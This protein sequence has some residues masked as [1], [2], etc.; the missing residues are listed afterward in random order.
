MI[1]VVDRKL[2]LKRSGGNSIWLEFMKNAAHFDLKTFYRRKFKAVLASLLLSEIQEVLE[3]VRPFYDVL[4][5]FGS[6]TSY[7]NRKTNIEK[8]VK[9]VP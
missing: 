7:R 4:V 9:R 1:Q 6:E 2:I 8:I 5:D 3:S